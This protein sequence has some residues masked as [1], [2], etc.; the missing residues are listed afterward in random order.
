MDSTTARTTFRPTDRPRE[1][2]R[3]DEAMRRWVKQVKGLVERVWQRWVPRRAIHD[4]AI[5][6][7]SAAEVDAVQR[8]IPAPLVSPYSSSLQEQAGGDLDI[9]VAWYRGVPIGIG[10]VGW[11]R[12]HA[13]QITQ[14]WRDIPEIYRLFV[15]LRYRSLGVGSRLMDEMESLAA[16]RGCE[17][18]GL[19]VSHGNPRARALYE[20]RGYDADAVEFLNEYAVVDRQGRSQ[21]IS[22]RSVYL[23][24][25]VHGKSAAGC[26][27]S[28]NED[29]PR[30][31]LETWCR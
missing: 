18:I 27:A 4:I 8:A 28:R 31:A 5:R 14:R 1:G 24:K 11:R 25:R 26:T 21:T 29:S 2:R 22:D 19:G 6:R 13:P 20:R 23:V 30:R 3:H 9:L 16:A 12:Q 15:P 10:F 7:L 17:A